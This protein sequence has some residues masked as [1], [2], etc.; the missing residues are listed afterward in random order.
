M[1]GQAGDFMMPATSEDAAVLRIGKWRVDPGLDE[2]SSDGRTVR[3]EP[4]AMRLLLCL[5]GHADRPVELQQLLDEVW[6]GVVVAP[7][8]VYQAIA[9]LRRTL[10]DNTEHPTYIDTVPRKGYRLIAPVS[11]WVTGIPKGTEPDRPP[12]P[13]PSIESQHIAPER[14]SP[15]L[16]EPAA[17]VHFPRR[18]RRRTQLVLSAVVLVVAVVAALTWLARTAHP[19]ADLTTTVASS[20]KSIAVLPFVDLSE[21]QDQEYFV[22]GM[23]EEILD[24]LAKTP[25]LK[26]I[27]RTSSF[28]FKGKTGDLRKI[29]ATLGVSFVV[30]GSVRR[31]GD[32]IRLTTQL[33]D[34][35]SGTHRWSETYDRT[36]DDVL[37]VQSEIASAI[38]RE[39][40]VA[41]AATD[42]TSSARPH[43]SE[44]YT[45]YLRG[46]SA[47]DRG[48]RT[49]LAQAQRYFEE[50]LGLDPSWSRPAEA[51][52]WAH[53]MQTQYQFVPSREGWQQAR[54]AAETA[55]RLDP[56][57]PSA[58][59]VFGQLYALQ[60]FDWARAETEFAV[61]LRIDPNNI[62][63]L[64]LS[65]NTLAAL[66]RLREAIQRE[67][68]ALT[69]DPLNPEALE[70]RADWAYFMGDLDSAER[71]IRSCL[72][73]SPTYSYAR[74][75][76]GQIL[77]ARGNKEGALRETL[78]ATSDGGRDLGL[79]AI[80]FVLGNKVESDAATER[81]TR[82]YG[83]LW[84]YSVA[85][86]HASR[87]E[88]QQALEWLDRAYDARDSDLQFVRND[89]LLASIRPDPRYKAFL[90][91][92]NL[93]E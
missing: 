65:A 41:T 51:L 84:P 49:R 47:L 2:I 57:S 85:Q 40:Q 62:D 79:A 55:L 37:A 12:T 89:P 14:A 50:A 8:S 19:P 54:R 43:N 7:G 5:A 29:A 58:H 67:D 53:I 32:H 17:G 66:G 38:A 30:E 64:Q 92:M 22:D 73:V 72:T 86:A 1:W 10:G 4:L 15:P 61:A 68:A 63:A 36:F 42:L 35:R 31:Y 21:K 27:G 74:F 34:A 23:T 25:S 75:L 69:V 87:N 81:Q 77:L 9:Q 78:T 91:K 3:L 39:L 20:E 11:P 59:A 26:V 6:T 45:L 52:A 16:I 82:Q 93:P 76:L 24:L 18:M 90:L 70:S 83:E 44:A 88:G 13:T 33:V 28:Q 80:Y 46:R 56:A 60:E 71:D 48:D